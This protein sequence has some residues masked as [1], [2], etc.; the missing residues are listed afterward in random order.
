M[1]QT[2]ENMY[3]YIS[4]SYRYNVCIHFTDWPLG[5]HE[6]DGT[7]LTSKKQTKTGSY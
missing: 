3:N 6:N 2:M 1:V 4:I 5:V 7:T